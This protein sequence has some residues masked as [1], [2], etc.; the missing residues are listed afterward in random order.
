MNEK[1]F[2]EIV[3]IQ[4]VIDNQT[5]REYSCLL[6]DGLFELINNLAN[7][8]ENLKKENR[9]LKSVLRT[10]ANR[11]GEIITTNGWIYDIREMI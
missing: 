8:N 9:R 6:D 10:M 3:S 7:E 11:K 1:R 2:V 4:K 5:G